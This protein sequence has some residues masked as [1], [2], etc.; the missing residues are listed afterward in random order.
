MVLRL[1]NMEDLRTPQLYDLSPACGGALL[2]R[3]LQAV[4]PL[5]GKLFE[6]NPRPLLSK[7][8]PE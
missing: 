7:Q 8:A 6:A 1:S 2:C 5:K 3:R 4:S